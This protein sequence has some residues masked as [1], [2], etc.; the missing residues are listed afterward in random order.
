MEYVRG[1]TLSALIRQAAMPISDVVQWGIQIADAL[2]KAHLAGIVHR[3]L[4]PANIM[5]TPD[6]LAKVMDFGLAKLDETK[7]T[8][9]SGDNTRTLQTQAGILIGTM[10]YMSPEQA[11]GK[12]V[13][14]RSDVFSFGA[15]LHE[16]ITGR[17]AF[18]R[19]SSIST[20]VAVLREDAPSVASLR[21]GVST[22]CARI[23]L[24][25]SRA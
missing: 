8:A 19:E 25:D 9:D 14:G 1:D 18:Q 23:P 6:G 22:A 24:A 3:D 16:M 12:P 7:L 15:V 2:A 20:L 17:R 13:D 4:K 10:A 5:I 11:E 21:G